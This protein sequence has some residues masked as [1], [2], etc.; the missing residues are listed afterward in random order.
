MSPRRYFVTLLSLV[1]LLLTSLL[2]A[3]VLARSQVATPTSDAANSYALVIGINQ[4]STGIPGLRYAVNDARRLYNTLTDPQIGFCDHA[5]AVLMT[6]ETETTAE[7][8]PTRSNILRQLALQGRRAGPNGRLLVYYAGHGFAGNDS[9]YLVPSDAIAG[10]YIDT[11]SFLSLEYFCNQVRSYCLRGSRIII[12]DSCY[13]GAA[14]NLGTPLYE[15]PELDRRTALLTACGA[16]ERSQEIDS[17]QAGAFS[18]L[19]NLALQGHENNGSEGNVTTGTAMAFVQAHIRRLEHD[20]LV[21]SQTPDLKPLTAIHVVLTHPHFITSGSRIDWGL[22]HIQP[23]DTLA[24]V[25]SCSVHVTSQRLDGNTQVDDPIT[26]AEIKNRLI[27]YGFLLTRQSSQLPTNTPTQ[28]ADVPI[29]DYSLEIHGQSTSQEVVS[30]FTTVRASL[31]ADLYDAQHHLADAEAVTGDARAS[32]QEADATD[33][34]YQSALN[35][36]FTK[37]DPTLQAITARK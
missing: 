6:T 24:P 16:S 20:N 37:L 30:G 10:K 5:H 31:S 12:L 19:L 11:S 22:L 18:Y 7:L 21:A 33:Q 25:M 28:A 2:F 36:L 8:W 17:V 32:V 9:G 35:L 23:S 29:G 4:Y 27:H 3:P 15:L 34:A 1:S 26:T 13:S 14:R